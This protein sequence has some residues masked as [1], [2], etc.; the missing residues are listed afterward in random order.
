MPAIR[1]SSPRFHGRGCVGIS[2][3]DQVL[4][5]VRIELLKVQ[6]RRNLLVQQ[7]QHDLDQPR[8]AGR[9]LQVPDVRLHA[10]EHQRLARPPRPFDST[11]AQ[12][13]HLDRVAQA[14]A[15]AVRLDVLH[16]AW[17]RRRPRRAPGE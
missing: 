2:S 5:D 10:P 12:G 8:H 14:R 6:V 7:R 17:L 3:R 16:V 9:R 4:R 11:L 15:G 1:R 13:P